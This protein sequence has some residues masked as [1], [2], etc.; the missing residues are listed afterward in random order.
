MQNHKNFS[1][2][3]DDNANNNYNKQ[4]QQ[5]QKPITITNDYNN[6][7]KVWTNKLKLY[8]SEICF[9]LFSN[10]FLAAV[11]LNCCVHMNSAICLS[12]NLE[13]IILLYVFF[14][15]TG[16]KVF[17]LNLCMSLLGLKNFWNGSLLIYCPIVLL[18]HWMCTNN[19]SKFQF[20]VTYALKFVLLMYMNLLILLFSKL[21]NNNTIYKNTLHYTLWWGCHCACAQPDI[22]FHQLENKNKKRHL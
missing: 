12:S 6:K 22:G 19:L 4:K 17:S 1:H 11:T 2:T 9:I 5:E 15:L 10:L 3:K 8:F 18:Y 7:T 16:T 14:L 21:Q 13:T 20:L